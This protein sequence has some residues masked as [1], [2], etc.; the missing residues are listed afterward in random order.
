MEI[1]GEV[2]DNFQ[3]ALEK[4]GCSYWGR[5]YKD[6]FDNSFK[7]DEKALALRMNVPSEIQKQGAARVAMYLERLEKKG[8]KNLN[9][10]RII[11]LGE[12]G[13]GK[14]CLA[15][16]LKDPEADMT[17]DEE[18]TP[19]VE[20]T[21]W[22]PDNYDTNIHIWDFAGHVVTHAVHQ[23]FLSERCLYILVYDGRSERRNNLEYWLHH[24]KNYG[25][26]SQVFI[27]VNKRDPHPPEIPINNLNQKNYPVAGCFTFSIRDDREELNDFRNEIVRY[28]QNNPSWNN[29]VIPA[30]YFNVKKELEQY[31]SKD[32][33]N[34]ECISIDTF[35]QI[36]KNNQVDD[37]E[38]LLKDLHDLG[39][40]LRYENMGRFDTLVLN[41]EWISYGIYKIINWVREKKSYSIAYADLSIIFE[42]ETDRYPEGDMHTFLYELLKQPYELAYETVDGESLIIPH[43]LN[44]DQPAPDKLP[45]FPEHESLMFRYEVKQPLPS[46][47]VS[48]F[49]VRHKN[50][51]QNKDLVWRYGVVLA[52][53]EK[54]SVALV[55]EEE[56][57]I[58]V[59]VKGVNKTGYVDRLRKTLNDI[60]DLYKSWNPELQYR[61]EP[62]NDNRFDLRR[63]NP[64]WLSETKILNHFQNNRPYYDDN[65]NMDIPISPVI[66]IFNIQ[67]NTVNL[68]SQVSIDDHSVLNTFS[69]HD[70]NISLQGN[71]ND[72][73][74]SLRRKEE[75]E[76]AEELEDAVDA[77]SEVE[78]CKTPEEVQKKGIVNKLKRIVD[79]LDDKNSKLHKTVSSIRHGIGIAQEIAKDYNDIAQWVGLPQVPRQLLGRK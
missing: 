68:G 31:F 65:A 47:T 15:R 76:E 42:K 36:A 60:F 5:L 4:E 33:K 54:K 53:D 64:L 44:E 1:Y 67:A 72:L 14:T 29:L 19:G 6:L 30:N 46:N 41:P 79:D 23:F 50:E 61:I 52:D 49:I 16:R 24:V 26:G 48:R 28:I 45:D 37:P 58:S 7:V 10:A 57:M 38:V 43:L 25:K 55:R 66:Q 40:C 21:L 62:L 27:L 20:T 11:I 12:K 2:W 73:A 77:L 74:G 75:I 71:L 70:C 39:I 17:K 8:A 22:T 9:E 34:N 35:N 13:S 56:F 63:Y 32:E 59:S 69:F 51:I 18:S 78:Q 3:R